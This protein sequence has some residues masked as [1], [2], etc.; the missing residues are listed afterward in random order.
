MIWNS[1]N[2]PLFGCIQDSFQ[3]KLVWSRQRCIFYGAPLFALSFML[4]WLPW[5][6][7]DSSDT[8]AWL[9]GVQL[10]CVLCLYDTM[11]TFVLLA[12]CALFTEMSTDQDD[13]VRLV[14]YSQVWKLM[15]NIRREIAWGNHCLTWYYLCPMYQ[16]NGDCINQHHSLIKGSVARFS[17]VEIMLITIVRTGNDGVNQF[18]RQFNF[19]VGWCNRPLLMLW[20]WKTMMK[21]WGCILYR[22]RFTESRQRVWNFWK[23]VLSNMTHYMRDKRWKKCC[24]MNRTMTL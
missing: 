23:F 13:R 5:G 8:P 14:K 15:L 6:D 24:Q 3:G 2:D 16:T 7:Y 4:M 11:F 10:V 9:S 19:Y 12:Q 17:Q 1:V 22:S 21:S 18:S 20:L